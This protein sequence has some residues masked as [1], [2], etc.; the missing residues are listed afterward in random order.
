MFLC[1]TAFITIFIQCAAIWYQVT[2]FC[3]VCLAV[4]YWESLFFSLCYNGGYSS[5]WWNLLQRDF[6]IRWTKS[7]DVIVQTFI[8]SA[9]MWSCI[10][11]ETLFCQCA[12]A[13]D[14]WP[15][16]HNRGTGW[17]VATVNIMSWWNIDI[18]DEK[19]NDR[20]IASFDNNSLGIPYL[21]LSKN[22]IENDESL[23][24]SKK[25]NVMA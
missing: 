3:I 4:A 14:F 5:T 16:I 20:N 15:H 13:S 22:Q 25:L 23:K 1:F 7:G 24:W 2:A 8:I 18:V 17:G 19:W 10:R 9:I 6:V 12:I 21:I 11:M